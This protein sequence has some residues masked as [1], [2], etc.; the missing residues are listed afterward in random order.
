MAELRLSRRAASDLAEIADYTIAEFGIDQARRYRDQLQACF[1]SLLDNPQLG[2]SA[3]EIAAGLRR[4]RQ[5]AHVVFYTLGQDQLVIVR[6]LH[7]SM[8]LERGF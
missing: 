5:Q 4:I 7:H 2:R 1:R 6:V 8:D 3:K